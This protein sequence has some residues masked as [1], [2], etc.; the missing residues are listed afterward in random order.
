MPNTLPT[1]MEDKCQVTDCMQ[2]SMAPEALTQAG[3]VSL[4][5]MECDV[6]YEMLK[7]MGVL[8]SGSIMDGC[9]T[10]IRI[11]SSS[12]STGVVKKASA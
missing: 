10:S 1:G 4:L 3:M 5:M 11:V 12:H 8:T 9:L 6:H 2:W 7:G